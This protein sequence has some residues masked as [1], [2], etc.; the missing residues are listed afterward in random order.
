MNP[1]E[2][3]RTLASREPGLRKEEVL[4]RAIAAGIWESDASLTWMGYCSRAGRIQ[5]ICLLGPHNARKPLPPEPQP[6]P[7]PAPRWLQLIRLLFQR[8]RPAPGG[9]IQRE[10]R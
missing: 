10:D 8:T 7:P 6:A 1:F 9:P 5:V 2:Y 4:A 3:G